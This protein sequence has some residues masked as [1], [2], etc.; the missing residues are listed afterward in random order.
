MDESIRYSPRKPRCAHV[1][2]QEL[3][4]VVMIRHD[5][6]RSG[7]TYGSKVPSHKGVTD[8]L[9][10][11]Q[12]RR[13]DA[14]IDRIKVLLLKNDDGDESPRS[15]ARLSRLLA[16]MYKAVVR[17]PNFELGQKM[18]AKQKLESCEAIQRVIKAAFIRAYKKA[19]AIRQRQMIVRYSSVLRWAWVSGIQTKD[20][21]GAL[22][23]AGGVTNATEAWQE[24]K[25]KLEK[26]SKMVQF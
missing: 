21:P 8:D 4:N 19:G 6:K 16:D 20:F 15:Q 3:Q 2:I 22:T 13:R 24:T 25:A 7:Q 5:R 17:I 9:M 11:F 18:N 12:P 14:A 23:L 26:Q 1:P 10:R